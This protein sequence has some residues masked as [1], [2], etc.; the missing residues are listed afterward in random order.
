MSVRELHKT[1][2]QKRTSQIANFPSCCSKPRCS[3]LR[4]QAT[5]WP[6]LQAQSR[7]KKIA[8]RFLER[9][10]GTPGF[11]ALYIIRCSIYNRYFLIASWLSPCVRESDNNVS[12]FSYSVEAKFMRKLL[13]DSPWLL[14]WSTPTCMHARLLV[15]ASMQN[16]GLQCF[17]AP[18]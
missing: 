14:V 5:R 11:N 16:C 8:L 17:N 7:Q 13:N 15:C 4:S 10:L 6:L 2:L 9:E 18:I 1:E 3:H 12:V